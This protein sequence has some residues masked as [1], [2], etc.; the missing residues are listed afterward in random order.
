MLPEAAPYNIAELQH[1]AQR[2]RPSTSASNSISSSLRKTIRMAV[3]GPALMHLETLILA[4]AC[5]ESGTAVVLR[6]VAP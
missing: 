6:P 1:G 2:A 5:S 4:Q 3:P